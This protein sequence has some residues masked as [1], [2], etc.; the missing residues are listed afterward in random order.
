[1][2]R[3]ANNNVVALCAKSESSEW[4]ELGFKCNCREFQD[5]TSFEVTHFSLYT[6][7]S[8]KPLPP[9]TIKVKPSA[10]T[11]KP[12]QSSVS[13]E[14]TILEL[15]GFKVEMPPFILNTNREIDITATV[16]YDC[17]AVCSREE[18]NHL[19]S[20]IELEPHGITFSE[21]V[22]ISIPILLQ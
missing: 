21:E 10:D 16:L 14:L 4:K 8:C 2:K 7:I 3:H 22:S 19:A 13:T 20:C 12:D 11:S 1:M 15:P 5:R 18:K 17:P 9:S 6:V